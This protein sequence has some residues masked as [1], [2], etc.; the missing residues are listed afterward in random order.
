MENYMRTVLIAFILLFSLTVKS[1]TDS[2][3]EEKRSEKYEP[4][5]QLMI[6]SK[7][8]NTSFYNQLN[9]INKFKII[10]QP[11]TFIGLGHN[12][13]WRINRQFIY[14]GHI[15]L[16]YIVP[17]EIEINNQKG[18]LTGFMF[19]CSVYGFDLLNKK[20]NSDLI[21]SFG[22]NSGRL[23]ISKNELLRQKN[24]FFA[25]MI[26]FCPKFTIKRIII[27]LNAQFDYDISKPNWRKTFFANSNKIPLDKFYQTGITTLFFVGYT[28]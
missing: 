17:Q 12:G 6:G 5:Y 20:K 13:Q 4:P 9:T 26:S 28:I 3:M 7:L 21:I 18:K 11:A 27:G 22:F 24:P 25:P 1:Q 10:Q 8:F 16:L 15:A 14:Y 23:K 2:T 19:S